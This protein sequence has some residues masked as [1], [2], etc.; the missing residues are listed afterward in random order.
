MAH[1]VLLEKIQHTHYQLPDNIIVKKNGMIG[2]SSNNIYF[3]F[4]TL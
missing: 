3:R 1:V 4:I 2:K